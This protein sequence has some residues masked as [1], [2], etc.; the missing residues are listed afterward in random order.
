MADSKDKPKHV[1]LAPLR[2][3]KCLSLADYRR[4]ADCVHAYCDSE[5]ADGTT[6]GLRKLS[7]K[8]GLSERL[9]WQLLRYRAFYDDRALEKA[10]GSGARWSDLRDFMKNR[11]AF[12]A[13]AFDS[14]LGDVERRLARR[15]AARKEA[16]AKGRYPRKP[17]LP[18]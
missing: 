9:L 7:R 8:M 6:D 2:R 1:S 18:E 3:L 11:E 12:D 13:D 10:K 5:M 4:A 17:R 14:L 16:L 15:E